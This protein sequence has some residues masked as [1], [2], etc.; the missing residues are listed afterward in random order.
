MLLDLLPV[1]LLVLFLNSAL[2]CFDYHVA[3]GFFCC[4]APFPTRNP[5]IYENPYTSTSL[6]QF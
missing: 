1:Q 3:K 6:S 4:S 2:Y 5:I